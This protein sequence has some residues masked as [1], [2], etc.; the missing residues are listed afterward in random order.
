M[1]DGAHD[2]E[3][4][5]GAAAGAAGIMVITGPTIWA[6]I[7]GAAAGAACPEAQHD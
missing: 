2:G 1:K 3:H 5:A 6:D 7:C 4:P